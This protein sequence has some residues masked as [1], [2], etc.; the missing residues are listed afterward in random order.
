MISPTAAVVARKEVLDHLRDRRSVVGATM[1]ALMGPGVVLLV[2]LSGRTG[3]RDG[4]AVLLGMLSVF[5]LVSSFAGAIDVAM[6]STAGERERRSLVP[7][8]LTPVTR[9]DLILGKWVAV[10][11]FA[12]AAVAINSLA[13]LTVLRLSAPVLFVSHAQ[14]LLIWIVLGLVPLA[15][16]GSALSLLV[17]VQCRNSKEAHSALRFLALGPMIVGMFLV[18]FPTWVSQIWF[19][20]PIVGQQ[21]LIGFQDPSVP[22]IKSVILALVTLVFAW[23]ALLAA[24][25]VLRRDHILSA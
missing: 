22:V 5:A 17:A 19:L 10:T 23:L 3:G 12:L 20:L 16:F 18:F 2:S 11:S 13:L 15:L 9:R 7:L 25:R 8:L 4:G 24:S 1:M 6:D 21:A 14:Q